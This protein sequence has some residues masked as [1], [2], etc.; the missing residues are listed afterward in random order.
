MPYLNSR[1]FAPRP[2]VC[3]EPSWNT[4]C[5]ML[6]RAALAARARS[7]ALDRWDARTRITCVGARREL[8]KTRSAALFSF[9]S[10]AAEAA[11]AAEEEEEESEGEAEAEAPVTA[12]WPCTQLTVHIHS[13][14]FWSAV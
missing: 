9:F 11:A 1:H 3:A 13:P 7:D 2:S 4:T 5:C 8:R 10:E 14:V 6:P 12:R